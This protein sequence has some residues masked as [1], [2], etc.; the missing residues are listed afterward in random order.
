[1]PAP[2]QVNELLEEVSADPA[3]AE[4]PVRPDG[5]VKTHC[6]AAG[7]VPPAAAKDRAKVVFPPLTVPSDRVSDG[8]AEKHPPTI[9]SAILS[10]R[11]VL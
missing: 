7:A 8:G 2:V 11:A 3:T 5:T 1:M 9:S 10:I 4:T 6:R